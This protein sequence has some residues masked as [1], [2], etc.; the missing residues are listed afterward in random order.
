MPRFDFHCTKCGATFEESLA[1]GSKKLPDCSACGSKKVEKLI[2]PP[3]IVFKGAGWYKTDSRKKEV[4]GTEE[5]NAKKSEAKSEKPTEKNETKKA[6]STK[7]LKTK[8]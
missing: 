7:D 2:A 1:F 6:E 4:S 5:K 8:E 3:G